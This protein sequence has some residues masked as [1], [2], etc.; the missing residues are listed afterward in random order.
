MLGGNALRALL[1]GG[2]QG[3]EGWNLVEK[4]F[5]LEQSTTAAS[6]LL[7]LSDDEIFLP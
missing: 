4:T 5:E 3:S 1:Q 6:A 7:V 2:L